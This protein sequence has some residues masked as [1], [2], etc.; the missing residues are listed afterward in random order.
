MLCAEYFLRVGLAARK[1]GAAILAM[2][3]LAPVAKGQEWSES[4]GSYT[5]TDGNSM[6]MWPGAEEDGGSLPS[7]GTLD[8]PFLIVEGFDPLNDKNAGWYY[9]QE[10]PFF[11]E[12]RAATADIVILNF[13][14]AAADMLE[15]AAIVQRAVRYLSSK[16]T[17]STPIRLGGISMGG[18]IARYALAEAED[19]G[20]P[21]D[22]SHWILPI[23][24]PR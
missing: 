17:G 9:E 2:L 6:R 10:T 13:A 18:V 3:L 19:S 8:K 16:K 5:D 7:D 1:A 4:S 11:E 21:L 14:D 22:V 15:N 23:R 20:D 24:E 12:A